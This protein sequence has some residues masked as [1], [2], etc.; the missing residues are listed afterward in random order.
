LPAIATILMT[1]AENCRMRLFA[2]PDTRISN[3]LFGV[4]LKILS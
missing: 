3:I 4:N 1:W 2:A